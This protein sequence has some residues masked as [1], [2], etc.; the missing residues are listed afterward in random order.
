MI[1]FQSQ[2]KFPAG[3]PNDLNFNDGSNLRNVIAKFYT[4]EGENNEDLSI[5]V[6]HQS[7]YIIGIS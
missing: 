5:S 4:F 6:F 1:P 3:S 7:V 2:P